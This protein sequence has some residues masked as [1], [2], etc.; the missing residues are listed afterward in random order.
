MAAHASTVH[1]HRSAVGVAALRH[2]TNRF[3]NLQRAQNAGYG[4]FTDT[5]GIAGI[6]MPG[7]GGMGVHFVDSALVGD[8]AEHALRPEAMVYRVDNGTLRLAAIEYVVIVSA[9]STTHSAPPRLFGQTFA[10]TP[11][12]NR[13]GLP[14]YYSLHVWAW[15]HNPAGMFAPYNP[16]VRC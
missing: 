10:L 3:D 5:A 9:W 14:A 16:R 7:V 1:R 2:A 11:A 6:A 13:F 15:Y 8:P 4:F 12:G